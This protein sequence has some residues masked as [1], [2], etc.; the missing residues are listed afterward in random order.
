L[1]RRNDKLSEAGWDEALD[2]VASKFGK[3][4][5]DEIAVISSAKCTNVRC[6]AQTISTIALDF[7]MPP[8]WWA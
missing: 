3:Y 1:I 4:K 6:W 8:A 7:A 2:L 5:G